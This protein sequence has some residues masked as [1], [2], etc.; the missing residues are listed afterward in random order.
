MLDKREFLEN[1]ERK[2]RQENDGEEDYLMIGGQPKTTKYSKLLTKAGQKPTINQ[3]SFKASK[4]I[5]A[6]TDK[7]TDKN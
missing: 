3:L 5:P 6:T 1:D 2:K 7:A 4:K